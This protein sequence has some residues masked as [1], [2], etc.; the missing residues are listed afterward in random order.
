M[1]ILLHVCCAPCYIYP[2]Q[3][4]Q[5]KGF[6]V[7]GFFYNPNIHPFGEYQK[8][9][10]A[11]EGLSREDNSELFF[12]QYRPREFFRALGLRKGLPERCALCWGLRLRQTAKA[13][14]ENGF[15]A[16][17]TTLLVSPYQNQGLLKEIGAQI[18]CCEGIEFYYE[19]FRPGFNAAH[20]EAKERG[21][22]CQNYCGCVYSQLERC[23][24][25]VKD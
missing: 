21:L 11:L 16:F 1:N 19:D 4:L 5:E 15:S 9:R 24:K 25:S 13:A 14:K 22:Y 10:H 8:R 12:P 3:R 2:R 20:R 18:A 7:K 23:R 17:T 6:S